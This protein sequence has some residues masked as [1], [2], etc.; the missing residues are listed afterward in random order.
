[1]DAGNSPQVT[2]SQPSFGL[3]F[4]LPKRRPGEP[5]HYRLASTPRSK[6]TRCENRAT[7][8]LVHFWFR[9]RYISALS[10]RIFPR[11]PHVLALEIRPSRAVVFIKT[12]TG[13]LPVLFQS[14]VQ[15]IL[16]EWFLPDHVVLKQQKQGEVEKEI[17]EELFDAEADAY[18]R[19]KPLQGVVIP[20]CYGRVSYNGTRALVLER[21]GGVSM[22]SPEG[23]TLRLE[24]LSALFQ[25]CY[26][27]LTAMAACH[28]DPNLANFQL[29]DGR[30]M[31]LDLDNV[32]FGLPADKREHFTK[33][34]IWDL[35]Y[36]YRT[37]Q[38]HFWHEGSLEEVEE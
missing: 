8:S 15:A 30:I 2:G 24:E 6:A 29:V 4:G 28:G 11:H 38:A 12:F 37:V 35:A 27:A 9:T 22:F 5:E 10:S 33:T 23:A 20:T 16:P 14:W 13:F 3:P 32:E 25:P 17:A 36:R 34:N 7:P 18:H 31:A 19:L 1:M 26:Q 21:I